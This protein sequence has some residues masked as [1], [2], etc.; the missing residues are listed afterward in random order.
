MCNR[1]SLKKCFLLWIWISNRT[2]AALLGLGCAN[3]GQR[4]W[5]F[6]LSFKMQISKL[7]HTQ[8]KITKLATHFFIRVFVSKFYIIPAKLKDFEKKNFLSL[9]VY[10]KY[11]SLKIVLGV[12]QSVYIYDRIWPDG[13]TPVGNYSGEST[14]PPTIP[15]DHQASVLSM[16]DHMDYPAY[17]RYYYRIC[18][19]SFIQCLWELVR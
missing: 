16:I 5:M 2:W 19:Y 11:G 14:N 13:V 6:T 15:S 8:V 10:G 9:A 17:I 7:K 18:L 12:R 4:W 1:L 3:T